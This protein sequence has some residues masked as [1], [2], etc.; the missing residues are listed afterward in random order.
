MWTIGS[1]CPQISTHAR[2]RTSLPRWLTRPLAAVGALGLVLTGAVACSTEDT[3]PEVLTV[4]TSFTEALTRQDAPAAAAYTDSPQAATQALERVFEGLGAENVEFVVQLMSSE[5]ESAAPGPGKEVTFT[6]GSEWNF[7]EGPFGV[8]RWATATSGVAVEDT[9]GWRITWAPQLVV[10]ELTA[11]SSVRFRV[12]EPEPPSVLDRAGAELMAQQRV[13]IV[14]LDPGATASTSAAAASLAA[15]LA[16]VVPTLTAQGIAET[17]SSGQGKQVAVV[18]LRDADYLPVADQL[19]AIEGVTVSNQN[20]LLTSSK[21]LNSPVFNDLRAKW[22]QDQADAAGWTVELIQ[23]NGEVVELAGEE[24]LAP[25]DVN[26]TM[27]LG[28]QLAAQDA[29]E[30]IPEAAAMVVLQPSNGGVLAV[31]QNAA[32][33][34]EGPLALTGL[35]PPGSTFKTIT[36]TAAMDEGLV[37]IDDVV[38]CPGRANLEGREIPNDDEFDL[39]EVP[40]RTAF[41]RSCNTTMAELALDLPEDA[42]TQMALRFGLGVDYTT[43]GLT[44][45]T[46]SVP[47]PESPAG[48]V[49]AAIGQGTVTATPFGMALVAATVAEGQTPLPMLVEG[50]PA[51]ADQTPPRVPDE[52]M[53]QLREMMRAV[54]TEGTAT[55]LNDIPDVL[56]KTGTAE[57]G[58]EGGA[59]GWF[60]GVRGDLA[61]AVFIADAGSSTP[62]VDAAGRFLRAVG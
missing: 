49:E 8:R 16:P 29:L 26:S 42:L 17:I 59:H 56:G 53:G 43:P 47:V 32:A 4:L 52:L 2:R 30:S 55:Q 21:Q 31:A 36:V 25:P 46:G 19:A 54:V 44:T 38:A 60:I 1:V 24:G 58:T 3:E 13:N 28:L 14:N 40:L 37:G 6:L 10:P 23:P 11:E 39:G 9:E 34:D 5:E 48:V 62:A 15:V 33:Y 41:A 22:E 45:I 50:D 27:D 51:T 20:R 57:H 35:Y 61:F 18:V 12:T 7:G